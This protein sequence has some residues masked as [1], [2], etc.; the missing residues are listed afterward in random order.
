MASPLSWFRRNQKGMLIVFGTLLMA[1]F[2]LGSVVDSL[3]SQRSIG[4]NSDQVAVRWDGGSFTTNQLA[5]LRFQHA[6]TLRFL[7]ELQ[8]ISAEQAE[9]NGETFRPRAPMIVP[10]QDTGNRGDVNRQILDHYLLARRASELGV[11][12]GDIAVMDYLQAVSANDALTVPDFEMLCRELFGGRVDFLVIKNQLKRELAIMH[13]RQIMQVGL[14]LAPNVTESWQA[15]QKFNERIECAV[16]KFPVVDFEDGITATPP[17]AELRALFD[18]GRYR[19]PDPTGEEPGFKT[20]HKLSATLMTANYDDFVQREMQKISPEQVQAEYDRLAEEKNSLVM[21]LVPDEPTENTTDVPQI[22]DPT[23][24]EDAPPTL[25]DG[26]KG[27][28][29]NDPQQQDGKTADPATAKGSEGGTDQSDD[30]SKTGEPKKD[31]SQND[32]PQKDEKGDGDSDGFQFISTTL[33]RPQD[34]QPQDQKG[35][36]QS[37]TDQKSDKS[38]EQQE[39]ES[40]EGSDT[41]RSETAAGQ[42]DQTGKQADANDPAMP[43]DQTQADQTQADQTQAEPG[44][45]LDLSDLQAPQ[46]RL[47]PLDEELAN[48]IKRVLASAPARDAMQEAINEASADIEEYWGDY[49]LWQQTKDLPVREREPKPDPVDFHQ[50]AI[51]HNLIPQSVEL[52]TFEQLSEEPMGKINI[53]ISRPSPFP[54]QPSQQ[55]PLPLANYLFDQF[56]ELEEYRPEIVPE[57]IFL[58]THIAFLEEKVEPQIRTFE[59]ARSDVEQFWRRQ[60]AVDR[61]LDAAQQK[62]DELRSSSQTLVEKFPDDAI[63]TGEFTW[64]NNSVRYPLLPGDIQP[65]ETF[66][67]T[68]FSLELNEVGV[69]LDGNRE[70][71]CLIQKTKMDERDMETMRSEFFASLSSNQGIPANIN[72]LYTD[73]LRGVIGEWSRQLREELNVQWVTE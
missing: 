31:G 5:N 56:Y 10:I 41:G 27:D 12:V 57:Y 29:S 73:G 15:Y 52:M 67:E 64:F 4:N 59:E 19:Y 70:N 13:M 3:I 33:N 68:A 36:Q 32:G 2:G 17:D 42:Q 35:E 72:R 25:D 14:P 11:Q 23:K 28:S 47:K 51:K 26:K 8:R 21:E 38:G 49:S 61:A 62:A 1:V 58:N 34:K 7:Q 6:Q 46:R 24:D 22:A 53:A 16:L 60:K 37:E 9:R 66:M 55:Q 43:A 44:Q 40:S 18:K 45:G 65:G 30:D 39:S 20:R 48:R 54:G 71:A 50:V 69:A 63:S